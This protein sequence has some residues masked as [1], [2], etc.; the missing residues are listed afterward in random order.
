[1]SEYRYPLNDIL[2]SLN[3]I[4]GLARLNAHRSED[5]DHELVE[6]IL[7][8]AGKLSEQC[9]A[10]LN[11]SGDQEGSTVIDGNV[12][13]AKGFKEAFREYVEGGWSSLAGSE[14]FGG[15]GLPFALA[16]AVNE[17]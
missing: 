17:G 7:T 10:P 16:A 8:E 11:H 6:A 3:D 12:H 15:Q 1:M 13:E 4:A 5:V 14:E 2:F 9:I